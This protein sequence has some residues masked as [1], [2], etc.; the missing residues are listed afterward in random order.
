MIALSGMTEGESDVAG[1]GV[2][3]TDA[4][5][6]VDQCMSTGDEWL[7]LGGDVCAGTEDRLVSCCVGLQRGNGSDVFGD[8]FD[9]L[10]AGRGLVAV[11]AM[12]RRQIGAW[13]WSDS[14]ERCPIWR[15]RVAFVL[16]VN[17]HVRPTG[18]LRRC[19]RCVVSI[20][21]CDHRVDA[22]MECSFVNGVGETGAPGVGEPLGIRACGVVGRDQC[23]TTI[24][25]DHAHHPFER[26]ERY[27]PLHVP[28]IGW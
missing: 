14:I 8:V 21:R 5:A 24:C 11:D 26:K 7:W 25:V 19:H 17:T 23:S 18:I 6:A 13:T 27:P 2:R 12:N 1:G 10:F 9:R 16:H 20:A 3:A 15:R 22:G 28:R 4:I